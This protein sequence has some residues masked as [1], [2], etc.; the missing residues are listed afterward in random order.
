MTAS[1]VIAPGC[2]S[3]KSVMHTATF[4]MVGDDGLTDEERQLQE[5]EKAAQKQA[6]KDAKA[7]KKAEK[8]A[9]KQAKRNAEAQAKADA[10]AAKETE[11][12]DGGSLL[13]TMTFGLVGEDDPEKEAQKQAEREAKAEREAQEKAEKETRKQAKRDAEEQEKAEKQARKE[14]ERE[15]EAQEKAEKQ[16]AKEAEAEEG[17][18]LLNTMTFGLLGEDDPEEEARKEEERD[19]KAEREA[20][21]KAEKEARKQARH[22]AEEQEEAEKEAQKQAKR[23]AEEQEKADKQAR[24]EEERAAREAAKVAEAEAEAE[25]PAEER[26]LASK[27]TFGLIGGKKKKADDDAIE[28]EVDEDGEPVEGVVVE[29]ATVVDAVGEDEKL[30]EVVVAEEEVELD[31]EQADEPEE[32]KRSLASKLTLGLVGES[33]PEKAAAQAERQRRLSQL[34]G[35]D[36]NLASIKFNTTVWEETSPIT[37]NPMLMADRES[38]SKHHYGICDLG[39]VRI[40][41]E[42]MTFDGTWR[43]SRVVVGATDEGVMSGSSGKGN[44]LF[45]FAYVDGTTECTFGT[46]T[47]TITNGVINIGGREAP[48]GQGGKLVVLSA[49]GEVQGVYDI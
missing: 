27:M 21:E 3:S 41:V 4:G 18:G 33:D 23:E 11:A 7:Q 29:E 8:Q 1:L 24:K 9:R 10:Q 20:Q 16:A 35:V 38:Y 13:N 15:A 30:E 46:V 28:I 6:E 25:E 14:A 12:E 19:A 36:R 17:G 49:S 45:A 26:S 5:A 37:G 47:F 44:R 2:A 40:A 22:E 31:A 42:D 32:G 43:T 48:I 34:S 39:D